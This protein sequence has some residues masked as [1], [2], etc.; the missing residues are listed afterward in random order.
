MSG[1]PLAG[2]TIWYIELK[3]R[4]RGGSKWSRSESYGTRT[5]ALAAY[6]S[7]K[8]KGFLAWVVALDNT[9]GHQLAF[10]FA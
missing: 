6:T 9:G 3:L 4:R 7:W 5:E 10:P 2:E 8:A 1:A